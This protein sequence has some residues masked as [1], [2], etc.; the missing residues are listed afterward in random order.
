MFCGKSTPHYQKH[1]QAGVSYNCVPVSD[2]LGESSSPLLH[3]EF[4]GLCAV[5]GI[6][7]Y[8]SHFRSSTASQRYSHL[9]FDLPVPEPCSPRWICWNVW[10]HHRVVRSTIGWAPI[11]WQTVSQ[12][13]QGL[14]GTWRIYSGLCD[15]QPPRLGCRE[16][17]P[18]HNITTTILHSWY[19]DLLA[20]WCVWQWGQITLSLPHQSKAHCSRGPGL[21]IGVHV[22]T[23]VLP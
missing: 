21:C 14:L 22:Q 1:P 17:A 13:P 11:I 12:Y 3:A 2:Q 4:F 5:W 20:K 18:N 8:K 16:A 6:L 23:V 10:G 9:G 19:R 7:A 15:G